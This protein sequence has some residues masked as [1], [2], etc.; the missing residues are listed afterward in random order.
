MQT[1][2]VYF[3]VSPFA[4]KIKRYKAIIELCL[5]NLIERNPLILFTKYKE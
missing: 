5:Q 4:Q 2:F 3:S 1:F